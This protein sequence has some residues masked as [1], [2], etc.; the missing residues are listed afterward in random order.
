MLNT[1]LSRVAFIILLVV[2]LSSW[3]YGIGTSYWTDS[4]GAHFW[5]T[6]NNWDASSTNR[7][8]TS[9]DNAWFWY[10]P[11]TVNCVIPNG[12]NA[13]C[14]VINGIGWNNHTGTLTIQAG[15]SLTAS[16]TITAS[17]ILGQLGTGSIVVDG[18][19][20]TSYNEMF[21]GHDAAGILDVRSGGA[22]I[23][24][25]MYIP[26]GTGYG[27][28]Y[29]RGGTIT[30]NN[31]YLDYGGTSGRGIIVIYDGVIQ[32][33]GD[34]RTY[35][36]PFITANQIKA[37]DGNGTVNMTYS[38]GYTI[39]TAVPGP[40]YWNDSS[41]NHLWNDANNW[42]NASSRR[43][44]GEDTDAWFWYA[45]TTVNCV[46][47]NGTN[48]QCRTIN[49]VGWNNH[50]G[51]LTIQAG[52]SLTA[53][54]TTTASVILGQLG[55]ST[56]VVDGGTLN[57][58]YQ[59]FIGHDANGILDVRSGSV[60]AAS[61]YLPVGSG[62]GT[63]Y[64]HGGTITCSSDL[65]IDNGGTSGRGI[66]DITKGLI[67]V[68]GDRVSYYQGF[69]NS[70][71]ITAYGGTGTVQ[72]VYDSGSSRQYTMIYA[73]P[74]P[75]YWTGAAGNGLWNDANNWSSSSDYIPPCSKSDAIFYYATNTDS[76]V[77]A[78]TD[79]YCNVLNGIGWYGGL[80]GTMTIQPGAS[81]TAITGVILGNGGPSK[82]VL[83][84]GKLTVGEISSYVYVG[85][86]SDGIL[87]INDGTATIYALYLPISNGTG[88]LQL[89]G[90]LLTVQYLN[91][92]STGSID[93]T[94]GRM[95][96]VGDQVTALQ[97]KVTSGQITAY[98]GTGTVNVQYI[99]GTASTE[100]S[101]APSATSPIVVTT[102]STL[103]ISEEGL[104][105]AV[106]SVVL[107][108]NPGTNVVVTATPAA[109]VDLGNGPGVVATRT[110]T[111]ANWNTLQNI[112]A[113]AVNNAINTGNNA[114]KIRHS[115]TSSN[116]NYNR[117]FYCADVKVNI[118]DND[119]P[120][121][122]LAQNPSPTQNNV[123][124][125]TVTLS[126]EPGIRIDSAGQDVYF[127][128]D[129]NSVKNAT[130][131]T[132]GIYKGRQSA[133]TYNPGSL[134]EDTY[135][136][137]V[138]QV[139]T[140]DTLSPWKGTVW[141]F[142]L[143]NSISQG[144]RLII[145]NGLQLQSWSGEYGIDPAVWTSMNNSAVCYFNPPRYSNVILD[146]V[147]DSQ[148]AIS[149]FPNGQLTQDAP[150]GNNDFLSVDQLK[151]LSRL[152]AIQFGDE[153]YYSSTWLGHATNWISKCHA[154]YPNVLATT[155]QFSRQFTEVQLRSY[156]QTA[157]PDMITY[158]GYF[159]PLSI[160]GWLGGSPAYMYETLTYYRKVALEGW[161][162]TGNQSIPFGHYWQACRAIKSY[163]DDGTPQ[164][165]PDYILSESELRMYPFASWV[166]GAKWG[167]LFQWLQNNPA[168]ALFDGYGPTETFYQYAEAN[169][170]SRN[171]ASTLVRLVST[172][173]KFI[174]GQHDSN[175]L[176]VNNTTPTGMTL[177]TAA[178]DPVITA[179]SAQNLGTLNN[180]YK[181]DVVVG[182]FEPLCSFFDDPNY[183]DKYN[184]KEYFMI[185]NG[186]TDTVGSALA[187]QQKIT[188][189]FDLTPSQA[190]AVKR[191]SRDTGEVE[192]VSLVNTGGSTYT[193]DVILDGGTADLF[194]LPL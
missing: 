182:W 177:W 50:T 27:S 81:L 6:V 143:A 160:H 73:V 137:R 66:I 109:D 82:L 33:V 128:T 159:F 43:P 171:L 158:D 10:A 154:L 189:T 133:F 191:V 30:C 41:S 146:A 113:T 156:V 42:S 115:A 138:D 2:C 65:V 45:P 47:P 184:D 127:G 152:V 162:G 20:L 134:T 106:Y 29:A 59:M 94:K 157:H 110:F 5:G 49:G 99:L 179:V 186:L 22:V 53:S 36:Q 130:T 24:A 142:V 98:S 139:R 176:P 55:T 1:K 67:T 23:A 120:A 125:G 74:G 148:W 97:S 175:G 56:I 93:I 144:Q 71:Q 172:D 32:I 96:V 3:A 124:S 46:I 11:T 169:R 123:T 86:D 48:A 63:I 92:N 180:G 166:F 88:H 100:L 161:D 9:N 69:V 21:V 111:S 131:S 102:P 70:G 84:G 104:T 72:I 174:P 31:L 103:T 105:S 107:N 52:G 54:A 185:L 190:L 76:I 80:T 77:P 51:T 60:N 164:G 87:Q 40:S 28:I 4:A 95:L 121:N 135:Y 165:S 15:G 181:G 147:P 187:T 145:Q 91:F 114:V 16:A 25:N 19:T 7:P 14:Y 78:G 79:A 122:F 129:F 35:L 17:V 194:F 141:S 64:A 108:T 140:S 167:S 61:I 168:S 119:C 118:T 83:D 193:L 173:V 149:Q 183:P 13:Q 38:G 75:T 163:A 89:D 57:S 12:T 170:Q 117:T 188:L 101:A 155:N 18:G 44:S 136:W 150:Q 112:T 37:F 68:A 26:V 39:L 90:G 85:H 58:T 151:Y 116:S 132:S 153:E 126:W 8:P 34:K 192:S 178:T 62:Y